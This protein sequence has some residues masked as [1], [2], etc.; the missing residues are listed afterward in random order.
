MSDEEAPREHAELSLAA[1][2]ELLAAVT[3]IRKESR[4]KT[5]E[6]HGWSVGYIVRG[7]P[8]SKR[9]DLC[10]IDP[11]D[12][13]KLFSLVSIKRKLGLA[14]PE[15]EAAPER[16][17]AAEPRADAPRARA[18]RALDLSLIISAPEQGEGRSRRARAPVNY[19]ELT[20]VAPP[21]RELVLRAL[22][23]IDPDGTRGADAEELVAAVHDLNDGFDGPAPYAT[24]RTALVGLLRTGHLR[25]RLL[26]TSGVPTTPAVEHALSLLVLSTMQERTRRLWPPPVPAACGHRL[27]PPPVATATCHPPPPRARH[28]Q[29]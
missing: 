24:V 11:G 12:G 5:I 26:S 25:R 8:G 4:T 28:H 2:E 23:N 18:D 14:S 6:V 10:C 16:P 13:Q 3:A 15:D 7:G 21:A 19:A 17:E 27:C 29:L 22:S 9:G 1:K 20:R